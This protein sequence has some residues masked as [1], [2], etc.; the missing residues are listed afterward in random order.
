MTAAALLL[1]GSAAWLWTGPDPATARLR[2]LR[3]PP[4]RRRYGP[5]GTGSLLGRPVLRSRPSRRAVAWRAASLELCQGLAAELAAGRTAHEALIR[6][7]AAVPFPDPVALRS[8]IAAA[9]DGG[10]V[11]AA[12]LAIAPE[13]GGEGL[14]RLAACWRAGV[15]VGGGLVILVDRVAVSLREAEAH[16]Q[17]VAA[18]LAGPRATARLLAGLPILGLAMTAGLGMRPLDFLFGGPGGTACLLAGVLLDCCGLWWTR[19]L[20]T[21]AERA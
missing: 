15:T 11:P 6:A 21:R 8:L 13:R 10:D 5:A 12:L 4:A 19:R 9:R 17:D 16:R 14:R 1:A 2:R 7:G 3:C 18:Q 20:V